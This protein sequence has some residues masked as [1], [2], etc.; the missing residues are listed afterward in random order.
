MTLDD[1]IKNSTLILPEHKAEFTKYLEK[2]P[3]GIDKW[4]YLERIADPASVYQGDILLDI[5]VC[6]TDDDGN[7]VIGRDMVALISNTCDMQSDRQEFVTVCPIV[8][9]DELRQNIENH[10]LETLLH[11]VRNNRIFRYFYLPPGDDL[12][13]SYI[14]FSRMVSISSIYLNDIKTSKPQQCILSLSPYGFYFFLVKLTYHL[15]RMETRT[16]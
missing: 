10:K 8:S 16:T 4:L 15:A 7:A 12:P 1:A 3:D 9:F 13:E 11:D 5:P 2:L 6:L 14:D